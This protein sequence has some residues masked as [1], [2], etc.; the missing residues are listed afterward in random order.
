ME[1]QPKFVPWHFKV[2]VILPIICH[3]NHLPLV[4]TMRELELRITN[5]ALLLDTLG[6][7]QEF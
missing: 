4:E 1:A 7:L 6:I 3:F 5:S 2:R